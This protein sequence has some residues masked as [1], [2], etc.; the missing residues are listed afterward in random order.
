MKLA[1]LPLGNA[2]HETFAQNLATGMSA[3]AAYKLAGYRPSRAHASRLASNGNVL[4]RIAFLQSQAANRAITTVEDIVR[5]LDED[6]AVAR[7]AKNPSAMVSATMGK[8]KVLGLIVNHHKIGIKRIED[9]NEQELRALLGI[10][11]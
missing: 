2:R 10:G 8:A 5:Q 6:R 11:G 4:A 7:R 3:D 9:M 1:S